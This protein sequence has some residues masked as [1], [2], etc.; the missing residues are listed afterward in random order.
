MKDTGQHSRGTESRIRQA[1]TALLV[2]KPIQ[3][4]TVKELCQKAR[5][6]RSTFYAHYVDIY[7]LLAKLE[8]DMVEDFQRALE[9]L[10][11]SGRDSSALLDGDMEEPSLLG[12]MTGIYQCLKDNEDICTVTLGENGDKAFAVRLLSLGWESCL[13]A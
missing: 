8:E 13:A 5:V 9:P 2:E 12:I 1:F 4:I 11:N 3:R 7:D 10:L 6:N